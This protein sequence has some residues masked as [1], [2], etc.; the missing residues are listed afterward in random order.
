[1][2]FC[3]KSLIQDNIFVAHEA[4][5]Y[6][7]SKKSWSGFELGLK[8]DMNIKALIELNETSLKMF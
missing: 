4:F 2:Y 8:V 7:K 5:H 3:P 6:L 1:M